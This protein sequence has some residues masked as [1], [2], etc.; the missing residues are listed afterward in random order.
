MSSWTAWLGAAPRGHC[1]ATEELET[2]PA[3]DGCSG[4]TRGLPQGAEDLI[5]EHYADQKQ[6][7]W[8]FWGASRN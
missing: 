3:R 4:T 7:P 6:C 8:L 1:G 2:L 5:V